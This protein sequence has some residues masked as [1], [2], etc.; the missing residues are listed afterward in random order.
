LVR[1][2]LDMLANPQFRWS[3]QAW[4]GARMDWEV[5][6]RASDGSA[7]DTSTSPTWRTRISIELPSLGRVDAELSLNSQQLSAR[8]KADPSGASTL[9]QGGEDFRKRAAAA[10]LDLRAFQVNASNAT[11]EGASS[12]TGSGTTGSSTGSGAAGAGSNA[13]AGNTV[14]ADLLASLQALPRGAKS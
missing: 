3:G 9:I 2:Q 13:S 14:S 7:A 4:P 10:G 8:I 5:E 12:G 6:R 11:P 1:Q